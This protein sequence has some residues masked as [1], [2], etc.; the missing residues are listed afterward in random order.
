[1][2]KVIEIAGAADELPISAAVGVAAG[3]CL[4]ILLVVFLVAIK[5]KR[6]QSPGSQPHA[7]SHD[8]T[9]AAPVEKVSSR[10]VADEKDPDVIPAKFGNYQTFCSYLILLVTVIL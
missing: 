7:V 10:E 1:M 5:I 4:T 2:T 6:S 8:K 9:T 3:A